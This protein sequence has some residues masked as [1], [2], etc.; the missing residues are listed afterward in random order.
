MQ[1]GS[2][3]DVGVHDDGRGEV[4]GGWLS[5]GKW[6]CSEVFSNNKAVADPWSS[7]MCSD[8]QPATVRLK[9]AACNWPSSEQ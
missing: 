5:A 2:W 8:S 1:T 7:I 4:E 3:A 6:W 9:R